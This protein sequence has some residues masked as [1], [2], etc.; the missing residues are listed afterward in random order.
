MDFDEFREWM[1]SAAR[2]PASQGQP[3]EMRYLKDF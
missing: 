3:H 2:L 1:M